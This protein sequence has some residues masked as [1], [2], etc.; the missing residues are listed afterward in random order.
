ML[1]SKL[2]VDHILKVTYDVLIFIYTFADMSIFLIKYYD[3][4]QST[5][6]RPPLHA[7]RTGHAKGA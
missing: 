1:L 2:V 7:I 4:P 5:F 3:P 6:F